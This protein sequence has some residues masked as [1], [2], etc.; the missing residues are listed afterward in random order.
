MNYKH[1]G[2]IT[3]TPFEGEIKG[4]KENHSGSYIVGYG[5]ATGHTHT[6]YV[7]NPTDMEIIKVADG[8]ILSLKSEG[9]VKHQEH[10]EIRLAPGIYKVGHERE[11][12]WFQDVARK[13]ID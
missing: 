5:E 4:D 3:F 1:Q 12:D 8:F 13:V 6:V 10:K 2:D 11:Y 7:E 9:V